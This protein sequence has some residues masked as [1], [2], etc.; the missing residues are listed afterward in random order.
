MNSRNAVAAILVALAASACSGRVS[1]PTLDPAISAANA[2]WLAREPV[3]CGEVR[4]RVLDARTGVPLAGAYVTADSMA[5]GVS[6]DSLGQFSIT[7]LPD[8]ADQPVLMRS[9][10][11]RIRRIGML[12]LSVY[13][14]AN[15]GYAVEASLASTEL[16]VDHISTLRIKAPGFCAR[17]T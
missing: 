5:R 6:T 4:G 15:L 2:D 17:A 16:H 7:V 8:A 1:H 14:P 11:V 10:V 13:L 9:A 12:E 3:V